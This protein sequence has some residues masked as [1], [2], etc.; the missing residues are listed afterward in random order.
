LI[1]TTAGMLTKQPNNA[2]LVHMSSKVD[3]PLAPYQSLQP[4]WNN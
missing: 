4:A 2:K 3:V 1:F